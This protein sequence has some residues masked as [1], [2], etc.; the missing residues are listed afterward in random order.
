[1]N[2]LAL[3]GR[4]HGDPARKDTGSGVVCEWVLAV[5]GKPRLWITVETWGH[6]AGRCAQHLTAGRHIAVSGT[7]R[8]KQWVDAA[9]TRRERWYLRADHVTFL[10]PPA[11]LQADTSGHP[12]AGAAS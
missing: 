2:V 1:M 3:T 8:T 9:G 7:L 10:D 5:D 11:N 12:G 6:L 4:L